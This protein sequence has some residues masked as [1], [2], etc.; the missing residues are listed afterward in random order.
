M[1]NRSPT[2]NFLK[3]IVEDSEITESTLEEY[4]DAT[5]FHHSKEITMWN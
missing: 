4:L 1:S 2:E 5:K 3:A